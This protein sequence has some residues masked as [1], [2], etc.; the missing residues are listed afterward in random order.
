MP[1]A[2]GLFNDSGD[3]PQVVSLAVSQAHR[4]MLNRAGA[5]VRYAAFRNDWHELGAG[6]LDDGIAA[7]LSSPELRR[8][9]ADIDLVVVAGDT[10]RDHGYRHLL[11]ILGAAQHLDLPT[12]VVNASIGPVTEGRD[13]L[14]ALADCTVRDAASAGVLKALGVGHRRVPDAVFSAAF[15]GTA[16]RDFTDHLVVTDCHP[17]RRVEFTADLA[18]VRSAWPGM[19][20]DYS[21]EARGSAAD[22]THA[23]ADLATASAVL[24]GGRDGASLALRAGV[25]FVALGASGGALDLIES[26][27]GYPAAAA[28]TT[29]PLDAR[30]ASAIEARGWF[31]AAAARAH[32]RGPAEAFSR[33]RPSMA[34][35]GRD[36]A[37]TGS[38][39]GVVAVVRGLTSAGSSVLHA[40]A[41][42]GQLV[43]ALAKSGLRSW[44]ADVARRLDRVDR[45]RYS[46]ATPTALPFADHVFAAVVVSADWLEHLDG[47]DFDAAVAELMRVGRDAIVIEIS[48][49]PL[50]AE[51]AFEERV[52]DDWWRRRLAPLGLMAHDLADTFVTHGAGPTGGTLL[53]LS[54][55]AALCPSC[56]R[57]HAPAD[58]IDVHPGV[59]LAAEQDRP[60]TLRR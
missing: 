59:L 35:A 56:R 23:V 47:E 57:A 12:Y 36:D 18:A 4:R 5:L 11:A 26:L 10:W 25:P 2:V 16:V 27:P 49:R 54:A 13:I 31:A 33:L 28:D 3:D 40:G 20:A 9:F 52:S 51:R 58:H 21:L 44:G 50:R 19:V 48:G 32:G 55:Q 41:G 60:A 43:E 42:Q 53:V 37:W 30:L 46:K 22:W 24:T 8:V 29:R 17:S 6:T 39:D 7:A 45:N 14:L 38:I 34:L 15:S 1:L